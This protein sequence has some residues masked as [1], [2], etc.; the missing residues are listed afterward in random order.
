MPARSTAGTASESWEA[1]LRGEGSS[2]ITAESWQRTFGPT[3]ESPLTHGEETACVR[4]AKTRRRRS[5]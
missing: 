3:L 1:Y 2:R 5:T 4:S